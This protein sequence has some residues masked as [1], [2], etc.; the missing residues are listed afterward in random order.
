VAATVI[1]RLR[2]IIDEIEGP[3]LTT[4]LSGLRRWH[5][6]IDLTQVPRELVERTSDQLR[7]ATVHLDV[8][9]HRPEVAVQAVEEALSLWLPMDRAAGEGAAPDREGNE[10]LGPRPS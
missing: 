8:K 2:T 6:G 10:R 9:P 4:S 5:V 3:S 1:D 7:K